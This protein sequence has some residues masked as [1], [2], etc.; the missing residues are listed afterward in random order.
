MWHYDILSLILEHSREWLR[1]LSATPKPTNLKRQPFQNLNPCH[2]LHVKFIFS[3]CLSQSLFLGDPCTIST[4]MELDE[5]IRLYEVNRDSELTIHG[6]LKFACETV[7]LG[8]IMLWNV[9]LVSP[10][11][12]SLLCYLKWKLG[13]SRKLMIVSM[14][15]LHKQVYNNNWGPMFGMLVTCITPSEDGRV[16]AACFGNNFLG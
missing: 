10:C 1:K 5:A 8:F 6:E 14:Y 2:P 4:Q 9:A 16:G 15:H 13:H 11:P 12:V 7:L 3:S